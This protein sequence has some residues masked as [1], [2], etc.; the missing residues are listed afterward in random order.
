MTSTQSI[1]V[2]KICFFWYLLI[3]RRI[4]ITIATFIALVIWI[5]ILSFFFTFAH[6]FSYASAILFSISLFVIYLILLKVFMALDLF[7][8]LRLDWVWWYMNTSSVFE[9]WT[10]ILL[11]SALII[12]FV[13]YSCI[14]FSHYFKINLTL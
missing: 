7:I 11:V 13:F 14:F 5:H 8:L 9:T 3:L 12:S 10:I 2:L 1:L 4:S 6:T